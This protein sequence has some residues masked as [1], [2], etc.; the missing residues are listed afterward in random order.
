MATPLLEVKQLQYSSEELIDLN[1]TV[2][3]K[4]IIHQVSFTINH[5]EFVG[6]IGPNGSGK[7]TL[8]K[9]LTKIIEPSNGHILLDGVDYVDFRPSWKL[10]QEVSLVFQQ[11][12]SQ[13]IG[14]DFITDLTLSLKNFGWS[15][16]KIENRIKQL[17]KQLTKQLHLK[18]L[19]KRPFRE[20]SGGQQQLL[21]IAEAIAVKP[22]LLILDEPTAQLDSENTFLVDQLLAK[23]FKEESTSILL[24]SHKPIELSLAQKLLTLNQGILTGNYSTNELLLDSNLLKE[25]QLIIPATL[26]IRDYVYELTKV[27]LP[28]VDLSISSLIKAIETVLC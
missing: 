6:L 1:L 21:A 20:L 26:A 16:A 25:N 14:T 4:E 17:T 5:H 18:S 9:L 10:H 8:S 28:L 3:K 22:K 12:S 19:I 23:I 7:T 15:I 24:I 2:K 27:Q 13:F 11:V